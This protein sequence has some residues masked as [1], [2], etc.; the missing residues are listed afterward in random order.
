MLTDYP[1]NDLL[2]NL[3]LNVRQNICEPMQ[4]EVHVKVPLHLVV[5]LSGN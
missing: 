4:N 5:P 2:D 1:D 3:R